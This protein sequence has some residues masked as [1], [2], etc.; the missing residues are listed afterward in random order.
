MDN[1]ADVAFK[2]VGFWFFVFLTVYVTN[3]ELFPYDKIII[4]ASATIIC[5]S[6]GIAKFHKKKDVKF[7]PVY[8]LPNRKKQVFYA[9]FLS[10]EI[11][12][13]ILS[14]YL[15]VIG[16]QIVRV[17]NI[18]HELGLAATNLWVFFLAV[19]FFSFWDFFRQIYLKAWA[20]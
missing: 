20:K 10:M 16:L 12:N 9:L 14:L 3:Y 5:V 6:Y 19:G 8:S 17:D 15:T 7:V 2:I 11:I 13:G 4:V 1:R 18:S